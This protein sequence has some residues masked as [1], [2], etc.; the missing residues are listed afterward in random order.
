MNV[1]ELDYFMHNYKIITH[2]KIKILIKTYEVPYI[3]FLLKSSI[4]G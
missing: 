2:F 3:L 1:L 4:I